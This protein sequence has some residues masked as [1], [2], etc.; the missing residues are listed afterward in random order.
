MT[1]YAIFGADD[2]EYGP[3]AEDQVRRWIS[4]G[5]VGVDS[6]VRTGDGDT[7]DSWRPLQSFGEF[8]DDLRK[9]NQP[10]KGSRGAEPPVAFSRSASRVVAGLLGIFLG[11]FGIHRF[12]LGY[13]G[14]AVIQLI[15]TFA[16]AGVGCT[17]GNR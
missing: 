7:W 13:T 11:A 9:A 1:H 5:R 14:I 4:E 3:I 6:L 2:R 16:T 12:Y 10:T 8:V 15:V 17:V